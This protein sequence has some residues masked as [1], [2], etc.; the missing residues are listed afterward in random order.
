MNGLQVMNVFFKNDENEKYCSDLEHEYLCCNY[1]IEFYGN[2]YFEDFENGL[3]CGMI[4][5]ELDLTP[6]RRTMTAGRVGRTRLKLKES[7][8]NH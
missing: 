3:F 6:K 1:E 7:Q 5:S 4:M 2:L 8:K